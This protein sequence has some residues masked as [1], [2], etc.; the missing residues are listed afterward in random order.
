MVASRRTGVATPDLGARMM[1]RELPI[2]IAFD[3]GYRSGRDIALPIEWVSQRLR[4]WR[5]HAP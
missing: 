4:A 2:M 3:D 5:D 1:G